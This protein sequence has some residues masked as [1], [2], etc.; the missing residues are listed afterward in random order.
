MAK[1]DPLIAIGVPTWGKV[2]IGWSQSYRHLG[3]PLGANT[4]ELAPVVGKPIAQARNELMQAAIDNGAHFLF[5]LGDDVL[6]PADTII[7]MLQ[8]MWDDPEKALITGMYWTKH[9][10]TQPYIWRGVQRGPYMDWKYGE[11]FEAD[12]AGCDCLLIR[13]SDEIKALG[14]EWFSTDWKWN[15]EDGPALIATEDFFFY[16]KTRKA[17]IKLWCD[18]TVQCIHEDRNSGIQFALTTDMPQYSGKPEMDLPEAATDAAPLVKLADIGCGSSN[19]YFGH[20]DQVK[21]VRFDANE[22]VEPDYRCDI[23]RLPVADQSFDVVHSRHVLEHFGRDEVI[24]VLKEW[25]RILRVGGEFRISVPNLMHAITQ[26]VAM[27]HEIAPVDP[28]PWWQLY[29]RQD[30]EN[31]FHHNGFTPRRMRLLLEC[32]GIFEDIEVETKDG[33][34]DLNIYA[35]AVKVRHLEPHALL[36][37]WGVIQEEEGFQ[38]DGVNHEIPVFNSNGFVPAVL[39]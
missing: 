26:I 4:L 37:E 25:T 7:K 34:G 10:P 29:G 23:R 35:K 6:C 27:E 9:W 18:S 24:D 13:L 2:S 28:Y 20:A 15:R 39:A 8:R 1:I 12:Y 16:T 36:P 31:D 19:P 17:G 5:M 22:K 32:L 11:F 38:M 30:D 14:P 21:V 33:E 3:G